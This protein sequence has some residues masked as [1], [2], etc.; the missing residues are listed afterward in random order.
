MAQG[1]AFKNTGN[2][3]FSALI[4]SLGLIAGLIS[5]ATPA[6]ATFNPLISN[7]VQ[8]GGGNNISNVIYD[9]TNLWAVNFASSKV[10]K[11][12]P[13][14]GVVDGNP[15]TVGNA[16]EFVLNVG[17]FLFVA[18]TGDATVT[19]IDIKSNSVV[20]TVTLGGGNISYLTYD[21]TKIWA[22]S[23]S[24][25]KVYSFDP[26]TLAVSPTSL[27]VGAGPVKN[28]VVGDFLFVAATGDATVTKINTKSNSVVGTVTLDGSNI[29]NL[30]YEQGA[31]WATSYNAGKVYSFD[32]TT[33][34]VSSTALTVGS[35]PFTMRAVGD[36]L[37]VASRGANQSSLDH[38]TKINMKT[39]SVAA[40][41]KLQDASNIS[42][43]IYDGENLWAVSFG[44]G[45]IY[46]INPTDNS[47][48][49]T[50]LSVGSNPANAVQIDNNIWVAA[51]GDNTV[52][53]FPIPIVT[54]TPT[55]ATLSTQEV[56]LSGQ[57]LNSTLSLEIPAG[58]LPTGTVVTI[59]PLTSDTGL[60]L[61]EEGVFHSGFN[62][63]WKAPDQQ[64]NELPPESTVPLTLTVTDPAIKSGDSI[65]ELL[66]GALTS[67]G[68]ATQNG[69]LTFKFSRDPIYAVGRLTSAP[70]ATVSIAP[71]PTASAAPTA[72]ELNAAAEA[73]AAKREAEKKAARADITTTLKNA[74]DLSVEAFVT[75]EITGINATNIALVQAE[76]LALPE[77]ARAD[78]NEILKVARKYEI[79][80]NIGSDRI[81]SLQSNSFIE[82]GLIPASSK[83]KVALVAAIRKLPASARDTYAEIK[84]AIDAESAKIKTRSERLAAI[85]SRNAQRSLR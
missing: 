75:A 59:S 85:I 27:T 6:H 14:T 70:P 55:I 62:I 39:N 36:F 29:S 1:I 69:K 19:K 7:K 60:N 66:N 57:S 77:E 51:T 21:G 47:V 40:N 2:R 68:E 23:Y 18:A 37:F 26:T 65:F 48:S 81:S 54:G 50:L 78:I 73:A 46:Q 52:T 10:F 83:N 13:I 58:S 72:G 45:K 80:G 28:I 53:N 49:T 15:L 35:N 67:V 4:L 30:I 74:K 42:N 24:A 8:L 34:S 61:P 11:I 82:I 84:A 3:A 71:A 76:L 33:L 9:G 56:K 17:D 41:I 12:N 64:A 20:G 79:V 16:P 5:T 63:V 44:T 25:G 22:T 38:V 31:I 43:L 32:P